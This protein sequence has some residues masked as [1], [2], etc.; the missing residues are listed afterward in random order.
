[1]SI[2][3]YLKY[4]TYFMTPITWYYIGT[5]DRENIR[6]SMYNS[7]YNLSQRFKQYPTWDK[8]AEPIMVKQFS[9]LF[10]GG[11][12]FIKGM[13]SDNENKKSVNKTLNE[14]KNEIE[15]ELNDELHNK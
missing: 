6:S 1:M 15:K 9:I 2:K 7:G 5:F 8:Y 13:L 11:N 10:T 14:F 3:N 4:A 12:A